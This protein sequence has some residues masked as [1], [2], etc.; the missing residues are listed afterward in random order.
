[1]NNGLVSGNESSGKM[2]PF[3]FSCHKFC[4]ELGLLYPEAIF[5]K[6]RMLECPEGR[7]PNKLVLPKAMEV[8]N[9]MHG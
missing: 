8:S 9:F 7:P 6:G 3:P 4:S 5:R 1:M 2:N